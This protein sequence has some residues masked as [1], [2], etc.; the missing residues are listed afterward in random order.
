MLGCCQHS[1][2]SMC[3]LPSAVMLAAGHANAL[4]QHFYKMCYW[5]GASSKRRGS[6]MKRLNFGSCK[7]KKMCGCPSG[8]CHVRSADSTALQMLSMAAWPHMGTACRQS[9]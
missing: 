7:Q 6:S 9:Q 8:I 3:W 5:N 4:L 1:P 2:R